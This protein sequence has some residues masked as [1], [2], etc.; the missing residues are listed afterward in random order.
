M[1]VG[2]GRM[3]T[4][5]AERSTHAASRRARRRCPW[6]WLPCVLL[7]LAAVLFRLPPL[8][9]ARGVDSDAAVV[10]LQARHLLHGEWAWFLWGAGYE[11]IGDVLLTA[12]GF[13]ITG[14]RPLT[15][16]AIPLLG[17]LLLIGF[18]WAVVRRRLGVTLATLAAL[19]LVFAPAAVNGV[20]L[21]P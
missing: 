8:L 21:Y 16:M 11:G 18:V 13:A 2:E 15:L 5:L 7:W 17:H 6:P 3:T 12:L 19:P 9:N 14:S 20:A 1:L 10:G 4:A